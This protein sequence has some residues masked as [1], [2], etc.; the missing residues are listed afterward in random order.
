MNWTPIRDSAVKLAAFL[1]VMMVAFALR[2]LALQAMYLALAALLIVANLPVLSTMSVRERNAAILLTLV[3]SVMLPISLVKSE[4]AM[5]HY[6]VVLISMASAFIVTRNLRVYLWG[7]RATLVL[8]QGL[9]IGYLYQRGLADFPLE[10]MLPESSANG[11]TSYMLLMQ[12]NYCTINFLVNRRSSLLTAATTLAISIVGYSRGSILASAA[13]VAVGLVALLYSRTPARLFSKL[14]ATTIVA[15]LLY[16]SYGD[17]IGQF[18]LDYT[19]I[20]AGLADPHRAAIAR[21]YLDKID[22]VTLLTGAS[23][24]GT[25]IP[26]A[27]NGNPHNSFIRAHYIFGL[28]YL[29]LMLSLPVYLLRGEQPRVVK[30][31]CACMWAIALFRSVS[32]PVLFPTL[33]DLYY[34]AVCF[35]LSKLPAALSRER[36]SEHAIEA[37]AQ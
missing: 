9:V 19:K 14:V 7:S 8:A 4:T 2:N 21:E 22:S 15:G 24:A 18:V 28:P 25:S 33:F 17:V 35:A 10:D 20:G 13:I 32:E 29:L 34:F 6:L 5:L 27:Y 23:Y 16:L 30:G 36:G 31:Y 12:I 11:V 26:G 1:F 3:L 37:W